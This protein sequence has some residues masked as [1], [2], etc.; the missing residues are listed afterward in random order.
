MS[1][2]FGGPDQNKMSEIDRISEKKKD[3]ARHGMDLMRGDLDILN[4]NLALY[5]LSPEADPKVATGITQAI[6]ELNQAI[7]RA[8]LEPK[9]AETLKSALDAFSEQLRKARMSE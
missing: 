4:D 1:E 5:S 3:D 8:H 7:V 6:T 2:M 9:N